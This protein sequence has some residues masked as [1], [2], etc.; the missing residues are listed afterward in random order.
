MDSGGVEIGD[1]DRFVHEYVFVALQ[2]RIVTGEEKEG[3][4]DRDE[5][6]RKYVQ[7]DDTVDVLFFLSSI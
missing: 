6:R 5:R 3:C 4:V 2:K 7:L 1:D